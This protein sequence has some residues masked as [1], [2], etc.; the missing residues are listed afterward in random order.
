MMISWTYNKLVPYEEVIPLVEGKID[1][2]SITQ[3]WNGM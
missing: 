3:M 2:Q 1:Q